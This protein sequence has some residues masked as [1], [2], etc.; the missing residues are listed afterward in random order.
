[1]QL[2]D[3]FVVGVSAETMNKIKV[4]EKDNKDLRKQ[5]KKM[6]EIVILYLIIV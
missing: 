3:Q 2:Q 6:Q 4:L 1:V 5:M